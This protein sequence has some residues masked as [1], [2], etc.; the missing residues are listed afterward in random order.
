MAI[1]LQELVADGADLASLFVPAA[2]PI[3]NLI[4]LAFKAEPSAMTLFQSIFA[5]GPATADELPALAAQILDQQEA[6]A[7]AAKIDAKA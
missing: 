4:L 3:A 5:K 2:S 6:D 1:T 7:E